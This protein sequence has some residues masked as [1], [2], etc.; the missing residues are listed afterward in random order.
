MAVHLGARIAAKAQGGEVLVSAAV[1]DLVL[2]SPIG[3]ADRG[4]HELK[5]VPGTWHLLAV[6]DVGSGVRPPQPPAAYAV[7]PN[8]TTSR[9]ADRALARVA[10]ATRDRPA[11]RSGARHAL[12]FGT[13]LR[14]AGPEG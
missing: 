7:A 3:F 8:A 11:L 1:R 13:R 9:P 2:G 5:G 10:R 12:R 6:T 14:R 4:S